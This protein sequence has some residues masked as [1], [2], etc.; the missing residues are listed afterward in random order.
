MKKFLLSIALFAAGA[1]MMNAAS[2]DVKVHGEVVENGATITHTSVEV[3]NPE[4]WLFEMDPHIEVVNNEAATKNFDVAVKAISIAE[5]PEA[6][7]GAFLG[8]CIGSCV[9]ISKPAQE[10]SLPL[11]V[12]A[13]SSSAESATAPHIAYTPG[14]VTDY[15]TDVN[16]YL[17]GISEFQFT[18]TSGSESITFNVVFDYNEASLGID[19]VELDNAPAEYFNMQGVRVANPEKGFYIVRRGNKVSKEFVR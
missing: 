1:T 9:N 3:N 8:F 10:A 19:G 15:D 7:Q 5:N 14:Y 16:T 4:L 12:A 18:V 11:S 17:Y 6:E 2:F 13:N